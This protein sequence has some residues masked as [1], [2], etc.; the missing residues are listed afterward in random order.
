MAKANRETTTARIRLSRA[1]ALASEH[2]G[3]EFVE[4]EFLKGLVAGEIPWRCARFEAP[5]QYSGPGPGDPKFWETDPD[6]LC[7]RDGP[8]LII[9]SRGIRIEGDSAKRID[10]AAAYGIELDR[11]AL[12]R[13]RLLPPS[14]VAGDRSSARKKRKAPQVDRILPVLDNLE[15]FPGGVPPDMPTNVVLQKVA[16]HLKPETERLGLTV[17]EWDSVDRALKQYR[18]KH[19]SA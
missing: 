3:S 14:D 4:R 5:Q 2:F 8:L 9:R 10:G 1:K 6:Q 7:T 12:V 16:N 19:S 13:L 11:S 17:P 15:V 18:A